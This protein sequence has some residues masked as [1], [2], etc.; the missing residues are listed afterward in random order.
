MNQANELI[1][2]RRLLSKGEVLRRVS[3]SKSTL[4]AYMKEG[5]FPKCRKVG[6]KRVAWLESDVENWIAALQ[7]A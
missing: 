7:M 1:A 6:T 5:R 4:Y 2:P 3:L